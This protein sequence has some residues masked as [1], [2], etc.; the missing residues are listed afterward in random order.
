MFAKHGVSLRMAAEAVEDPMRVL[1]E[2]D[3]NSVSGASVRII[4]YSATAQQVV[5]L[6]ALSKNG[7]DFGVNG[8]VSN[9]KDLRIYCQ[10]QSS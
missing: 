5:T 7:K 3:Y 2:P 9:E 8:W 4:G 10:A 1:L 6:I